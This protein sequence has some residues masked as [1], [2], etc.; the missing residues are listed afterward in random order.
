MAGESGREVCRLLE[1][2]AG[3]APPAGRWATGYGRDAFRA[4]EIMMDSAGA[5]AGPA[6]SPGT[7]RESAQVT[8][9]F[10]LAGAGQQRDGAE[11]GTMP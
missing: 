9:A 5:A 3:G 11:C 2:H 4:G 8:G 1:A 10:A 6:L 7:I